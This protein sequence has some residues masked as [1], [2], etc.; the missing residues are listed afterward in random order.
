LFA[1]PRSCGKERC[2]KEERKRPTS[3]IERPTLNDSDEIARPARLIAA[4][5]DG[6]YGAFWKNAFSK[7]G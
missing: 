7:V 2:L 4:V 6:R 1:V 3:N 5:M